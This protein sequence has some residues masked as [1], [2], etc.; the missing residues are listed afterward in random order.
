MT[1]FIMVRHGEPDYSFVKLR[2]FIGHGNDLAP[3][4]NKGIEQIKNAAKNS[5]LV[6]AEIIISSPYTRALQSAAIISGMLGLN[7]QVE[8][9]IYMSGSLI[10]HLDISHMKRY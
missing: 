10:N 6:D 9:K 4:T 5:R 7:I 8:I 2:G 1:K 3:L